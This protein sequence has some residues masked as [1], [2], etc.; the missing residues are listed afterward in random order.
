MKKFKGFDELRRF[1]PKEQ[2]PG[3]PGMIPISYSYRN[4]QLRRIAQLIA[5]MAYY[6]FN[7]EEMIR[8]IKHSMVLLDA[9]KFK[10]NWKQS[11]KDHGIQE[12]YD[13]YMVMR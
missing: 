10:L 1:K 9:E 6:D 11:E 12:L 2:Y 8:A 13:K 5:V 7:D 4:R 3:Y